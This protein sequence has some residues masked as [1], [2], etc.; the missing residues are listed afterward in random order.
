MFSPI[1]MPTIHSSEINAFNHSIFHSDCYLQNTK[2]YVH[3]FVSLFVF[4]KLYLLPTI[5]YE[6]AFL[7]GTSSFIL[8]VIQ[9]VILVKLNNVLKILYILLSTLNNHSD[10]HYIKRLIFLLFFACISNFDLPISATFSIFTLTL[11]AYTYYFVNII[12]LSMF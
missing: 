10:V 11:I 5:K 9:L 1:T 3:V 2:E 12:T 4:T 7:Y 6:N 8:S